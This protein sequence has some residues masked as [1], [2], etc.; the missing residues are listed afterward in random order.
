MAKWS[1]NN[2]LLTLTGREVL[3]KVQAGVGKLEVSRIV[4]GSGRVSPAQLY[5]QT[6]VSQEQ[7]TTLITKVDTSS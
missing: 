1:T 2:I 6:K 3:S 4:T 7:Q 5:N